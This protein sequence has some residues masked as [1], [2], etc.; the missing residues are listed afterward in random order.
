MNKYILKINNYYFMEKK[1]F[2]HSQS[3]TAEIFFLN[4]YIK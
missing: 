2:L 1:Q 4:R 3:D